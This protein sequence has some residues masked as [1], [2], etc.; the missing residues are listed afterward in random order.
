MFVEQHCLEFGRSL[1]QTADLTGRNPYP[2][3][4]GGSS[5]L[6]GGCLLLAHDHLWTN[7]LL[8]ISDPFCLQHLD[9]SN[10]VIDVSTLNG[11]LSLLQVGNQPG[12]LKFSGPIVDNLAKNTNFLKL[13]LS[14]C[15]GFSESA[16]KILL[17]SC[18]RLDELKL[19]W[20]F[21]FAEN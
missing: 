16:V 15:S 14:G 5:V 21:D 20:Y 2:D 13:N 6:T 8:N 7:C 19:S 10:S 9:I 3:V 12:G 1:W 11:L 18:S 4:V 17:S